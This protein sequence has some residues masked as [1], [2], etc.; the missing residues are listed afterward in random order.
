M[1]GIKSPMVEE[2][3]PGIVQWDAFRESIGRRVHSTLVLSSG[4]LIDP[5][6]PDDGLDAVAELATPRRIVLS[7]RHHYRH[8]A[9]YAKRFGCPVLCHETGLSHFAGDRPV[10]GFSFEEQLADDVRALE[11]GSICSEET[12]LLLDVLGGALAFGDGLTRDE[13][14]ALA[15]MPDQL[16]GEDPE[17][18][19]ARLTRRLRQMLDEEDFDTLLFAHAEPVSSGGR[20]LLEEFLAR[21]PA[22]Q[23][24]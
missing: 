3:V 15:F 7:N 12:A 6:E 13:D 1:E 10:Q 19:R 17:G 18:V 21:K 9:R 24:P 22:V 4:T 16:L 5:M 2:I 11:L 23:S 14:G 20:T 8:S